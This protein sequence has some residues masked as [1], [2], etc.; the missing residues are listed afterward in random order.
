MTELFVVY[1]YGAGEVLKN[2]FD[3]IASMYTG[4]Y[5][6]EFF[7][8]SIMVGLAWA[9]LKAGVTRNYSSHYMKWFAGYMFVILILLQPIEVFKTKG[10]TLY[11]RDVVTGKADKVDHLPPGLVI[12]AGIISGMGYSMTKLFETLFA[13]PIPN[14]LPYSKYGTTFASQ[15]RSDLRKVK[16]QNPVL[17]EN[18]EGYITKCML[19]DVMIGKKY[20]ISELENSNNVWALLIE[21]SSNLRLFN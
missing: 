18:L 14:Y 10:M 17:K 6:S 12:P 8:F 19:Y 4:G 21:K 3:A 5:M 13:S 7:N 1:T 16:I 2:T 20:D 15:V 11:I 9:G